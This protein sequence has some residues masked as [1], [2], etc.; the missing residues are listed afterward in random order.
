MKRNFFASARAFQAE[1]KT[2]LIKAQEHQQQKQQQHPL[3]RQ[4]QHLQ[5]QIQM[6]QLLLQGHQQQQQQHHQ[7]Q[8][9]QQHQ[10]L[11]REGAHLLNGRVASDP[12]MRQNPGTANALSTKMYEE[13]LKLPPQTDSLNESSIQASF[14][15]FG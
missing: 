12:S 4:W 9:Q 11:H 1:A 3:L 7:Q 8:Q 2:Q 14:A 6:Q 15:W 5:Q 13:R 10:Q